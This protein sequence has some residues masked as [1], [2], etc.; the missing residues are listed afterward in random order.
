MA[1]TIDRGEELVSVLIPKQS[2]NDTQRFI[3][4][5]G[6]RIIVQTGKPVEIKRKFAEVLDA[7]ERMAVE[8]DAFI[9]ANEAK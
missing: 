2:R 9:E 3:S 7:S 4:V 5:N 6:E 1:N 8:A